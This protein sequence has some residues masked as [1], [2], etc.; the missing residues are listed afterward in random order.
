MK[1]R[2]ICF[3]DLLGTKSIAGSDPNQYSNIIS[4]F[5][6]IVKDSAKVYSKVECHLFSDSIYSE[7]CCLTDLCNFVKALRNKLLPKKICF[8]AAI[9]RGALGIHKDSIG[10]NG[11]ILSIKSTDAIEVYSQQVKFSGA[12]I[13]VEETLINDPDISDML[14]DSIYTSLEKD[15]LKIHKFKDIKLS[16]GSAD[17]LKYILHI[18]IETYILNPRASRYYLTMIATFLNEEWRFDSEKGEEIINHILN[19]CRVLGDDAYREAVV[20]TLVNA[21]CTHAYCNRGN[22]DD[23]YEEAR[24]SLESVE[25][26]LDYLK[27]ISLSN[28]DSMLLK[29]SSKA[30]ISKFLTWRALKRE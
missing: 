9:R 11:E 27:L 21:I 17:A 22:V 13:Y 3:L 2:Y 24:D 6:D 1:D 26:A 15:K 29:D 10:D 7:A 8:N 30:I 5:E 18:F 25:D 20:L 28:V 23:A 4:N 16:Y 14:V 19:A 12:G